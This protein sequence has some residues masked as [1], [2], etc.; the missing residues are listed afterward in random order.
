M[1][2]FRSPFSETKLKFAI[3]KGM[4]QFYFRKCM[5]KRVYNSVSRPYERFTDAAFRT[6]N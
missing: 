5:G 1:R 6:L 2:L 4:T 3:F